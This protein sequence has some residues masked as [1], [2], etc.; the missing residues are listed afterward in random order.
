MSATD[1]TTRT[2]EIISM[3]DIGTVSTVETVETTT[4]ISTKT[5]TTVHVS[6]SPDK[7][8]VR[9]IEPKV[10]VTNS[11]KLDE[12]RETS[13]ADKKNNQVLDNDKN[14]SD[15]A[16]KVKENKVIVIGS[17][18]KQTS[19]LMNIQSVCPTSKSGTTLVVLNK[20]GNQMKISLA[21]RKNDSEEKEEN[22]NE[23]ESSTPS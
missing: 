4:T 20:E 9:T 22:K 14:E 16:G 2:T 15:G 10:V 17:D 8:V 12:T 23:N 11:K 21:P 18:G 6:S 13:P 1:S 19:G 5:T 3:S 7:E